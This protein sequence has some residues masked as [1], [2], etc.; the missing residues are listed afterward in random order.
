MGTA[1]ESSQDVSRSEMYQDCLCMKGGELW[2]VK[3]TYSGMLCL[4]L[5]SN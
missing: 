1:R 4:V 2:V 5:L 3:C